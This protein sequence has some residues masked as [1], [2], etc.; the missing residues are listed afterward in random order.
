MC[1]VS[2]K[3]VG[4]TDCPILSLTLQG[5]SQ[6]ATKILKLPKYHICGRPLSIFTVYL[7][8]YLQ[9]LDILQNITLI[10]YIYDIILIK[11]DQRK[12]QVLWMPW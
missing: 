9:H 10:L 7:T 3:V 5:I 12:W 4:S 11:P 8:P 1:C 2:F 6:H